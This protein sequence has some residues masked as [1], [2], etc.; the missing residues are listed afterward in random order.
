KI[1][2]IGLVA[3]AMMI[4]T[5]NAIAQGVNTP[6]PPVNAYFA[7]NGFDSN[8]CTQAAPCLTLYKAS[9]MSYPP[10]STINFRGGDNFTGCWALTP[11]NVTG[12]GDK[13]NPIVV[14]S[15][16][17]GRATWASN[18]SAPSQRFMPL[19]DIAG[20]S[21]ITVQNL[22]LVQK[23]GFSANNGILIEG[24]GDTITIQNTDI[25]GFVGPDNLTP[26]AQIEVVGLGSYKGS[27]CN[28]LNH[29]NILNNVLH[30]ATP[31]SRT[32]DGIYGFGCGLNINNINYSG[33]HIYNMGGI[34]PASGNAALSPNGIVINAVQTGLVEHNLVHDIGANNATCGGPAGILAYNADSIT[35]R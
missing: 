14:Q 3:F 22:I 26:G 10:G 2:Q 11:T 25:G 4:R 29:I 33:N 15:Y 20:V 13:N 30:G 16:G 1:A 21:G 34:S 28:A 23:A 19:L 17:T 6:P 31:T 5:V 9:A 12:G 32:S 8:P 18:C 7:A 27:G 24:P 35:I